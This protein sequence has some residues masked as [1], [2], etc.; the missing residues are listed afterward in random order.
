MNHQ[1]LKFKKIYN[2]IKR[3]NTEKLLKISELTSLQ[4]SET[5]RCKI[6][7]IILK[8]QNHKNNERILKVSTGHKP[9]THKGLKITLPLDFST[10]KTSW[11][12]RKREVVMALINF[13]SNTARNYGKLPDKCMS[14][15]HR[16]VELSTRRPNK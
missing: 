5:L 7:Y 3:W 11:S 14:I 10:V 9:I 16:N 12:K 8:C 15:L 13:S 2:T 1:K 4:K 6:L